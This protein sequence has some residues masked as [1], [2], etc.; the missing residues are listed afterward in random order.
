MHK[1][2]VGFSG[3]SFA[4]VTVSCRDN[5]VDYLQPEDLF[6][7]FKLFDVDGDGNLDY[8]E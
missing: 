5:Q 3:K 7:F 1:T 4:V 2:C 8:Q 6:H